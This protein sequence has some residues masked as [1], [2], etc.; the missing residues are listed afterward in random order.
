M[1][2]IPERMCAGCRKKA[3]KQS[4]LRL[5]AAGGSIIIDEKQNIQSRGIYVCRD[6]KC[7]AAMKKKKSLS[8]LFRQNIPDE[9]YEKL[10]EK[11]KNGACST[12][13]G[14]FSG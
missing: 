2:H 9:L 5:T 12:Q 11:C 6:E 14:G 10:I 4:L 1:T 3:P 7:I 8:R 13:R